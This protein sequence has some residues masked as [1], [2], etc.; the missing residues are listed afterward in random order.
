MKEETEKFNEL[1]KRII[2]QS[3]GISRVPKKT[4]FEFINLADAE[5]CSDYGMTLKFLM[6][7]T[8]QNTL[9][10]ILAAKYL[11]LEDRLNEMEGK[12]KKILIKTLSG[13][14]IEKEEKNG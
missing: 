14:K 8:K 2:E 1:K 13:K 12:P 7:V 11:E 10:D 5:F 3:L 6:D 4:K 9:L